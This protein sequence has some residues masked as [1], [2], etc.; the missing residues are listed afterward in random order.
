MA[1]TFQRAT[2]AQVPLKIGIVGPS[3]SGKTTAGLR[4]AHGLVPGQPI[5]LIDTEAGSA[6]LYADMEFDTL[7]M[8][9]PYLV[10]KFI[11]GLQA[12]VDAGYK[13]VIIDSASHEWIQILQDKEATD[14]RGGNQWANWAP[15]TKKHEAFLAAIRNCPIHVICCL[16]A[17]EKHEATEQKKVVKLG[18]GSEMRPGFEYELSVVFDLAMDH[19][20]KVS[21]D[22]TR[23][24]AER[25]EHV[26]EATGRELANWLVSGAPLAEN[27]GKSFTEVAPPAP[28]PPTPAAIA[29]EPATVGAALAQLPPPEK[30]PVSQAIATFVDGVDPDTD[31]K[32]GGISREQYD[33]LNLLIKAYGINRD[34]LRAYCFK[35]GH[36]LACAN[37][38]T[39]ARLKADQF[40]KLRDRLNNQKI[41]SKGETWSQQTIRII[42]DTPVPLPYNPPVQAAS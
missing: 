36:L 41:A 11:A 37:G 24:F 16:R 33:A 19:I 14:F 12:A 10:E 35:A 30:N 25:L 29:P 32:A 3:G 2:R 8:N 21:K 9:P 23:L 31:E 4:L 22:R 5:A 7:V 40:K 6:S 42:N 15:F 39:L 17:K 20:A 18:L 38:P 28:D 34:A 26:T 13:A 1:I 27:T